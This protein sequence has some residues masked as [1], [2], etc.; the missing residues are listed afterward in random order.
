MAIYHCEVKSISRA[1]GRSATAAAAYRAGE[2]IIDERTLEVHDYTRKRTVISADLI[3]PS[4]VSK[5]ITRAE[6]WNMAEKSEKRKDAKVARE[7]E[8][9]LPAEL[10]REAQRALALKFAQEL[11]D[12]Y[13]VAADVALHVPDRKGD[14]RNIHAHILTTT[15]RIT[16]R[17]ELGDKTRELDTKPSSAR[18]VTA[19]RELWAQLANAELER[20]GRSERIDARTLEAQGI[21]RRPQI[22]L[23]PAATQMERRGVATEKGDRNRELAAY[24]ADLTEAR[25]ATEELRRHIDDYRQLLRGEQVK[26]KQA[27][28]PTQKPVEAP[29]TPK[30]E[31]YTSEQIVAAHRAL[32]TATQR[33]VAR[34]TQQ[35]N[36]EV[37]KRLEPLRTQ[38]AA[39]IRE[40]DEL[41]ETEPEKRL[42]ERQGAYEKRWQHWRE[43][44]NAVIAA[45][46]KVQGEIS[47]LQKRG[48]EAARRIPS[49]ADELARKEHPQAAHIVDWEQKQKERRLQERLRERQKEREREKELGGWER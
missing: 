45:L 12:R 20:H 39:K 48:Y 5:K 23:G 4:D 1:N 27:D 43:A 32:N 31:N 11:A 46:E 38:E 30:T 24:N 44:L 26:A 35:L 49:A 17:G 42:L 37:E 14:E 34:L 19:I 8:I 3:M 33:H 29:K 22:H 18:E 21:E 2:K 15:R 10:P 36:D 6:L 47:K 25:H 7:Y 9:A 28:T 40:R 41:R 16:A 13:H